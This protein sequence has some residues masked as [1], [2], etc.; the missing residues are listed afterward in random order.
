MFTGR[1]GQPVVRCGGVGALSEGMLRAVITHSSLG[2]VEAEVLGP[3]V[4]GWLRMAVG[5]LDEQPSVWPCPS[6]QW[7]ELECLGAGGGPWGCRG[8]SLR[9]SV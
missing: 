3:I 9:S 6:L 2:C 7:T 8:R 4:G 1:Q 5:F